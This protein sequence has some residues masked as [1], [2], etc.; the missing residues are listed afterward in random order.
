[1]IRTKR[2]LLICAM[3]ATLFLADFSTAL[4]EELPDSAYVI[5]VV[6]HAQSY[7]IDC[8]IRSAADLAG[9]WGFN[10][11]EST[12][13][14][15]MPRSDNPDEGFVGNPNET[16][17]Q[18]PPSGYGVHAGPVADVLQSF[19]MQALALKSLSWDDL[20]A[21]IS[22]GR[23]AI[24]WVI[25]SMW[26]GTPVDYQASDG[27]ISRVAAYEHTMLI[28]GYS[29]RS[30]QVI[31]A[32]SGQYEYYWL[33]DFLNSWSVLGNMAVFASANDQPPEVITAQEAAPVTEELAPQALE[34]TYKAS[35]D[36]YTV[37]AG[38][39]LMAVA[40]KYGVS[41]QALAD[42]NLLAYPYMIYAGQVLVLPVGASST[43][44]SEPEA[45]PV[46]AEPVS[47]AK[48]VNPRQNLPFIQRNYK[49]S[50][51]LPPTSTPPEP[52]KTVTVMYTDTLIGFARSI[53]VAW[54]VV[55]RLNNLPGSAILHPGDILIVP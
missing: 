17:G 43:K 54:H 18:I 49:N 20:R 26:S 22:A 44:I 52:A 41:W 53:G 42:L 34:G 35:L 11:T 55:A 13:L 37:Q 19:G 7:A 14:Q 27:S 12:I 30:V 1:M 47:T 24:V 2:L 28:T 38:D 48:V 21:E 32:G 46:A 6:G 51:A 39:H 4:A 15:A 25:G 3:V 5:G 16:W 8:E 36:T 31:D 10:L 9:F 40:R 23:P 29:T 50:P 33:S 45:P